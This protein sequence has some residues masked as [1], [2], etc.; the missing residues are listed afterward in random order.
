MHSTV[1]ILTTS[2][3]FLHCII[4]LRVVSPNLEINGYLINQGNI[5][6]CKHLSY[7]GERRTYVFRQNSLCSYFYLDNNTHSHKHLTLSSHNNNVLLNPMI[8]G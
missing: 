2:L 1:V 6:L 7:M 4:T 5:P 3:C 8:K